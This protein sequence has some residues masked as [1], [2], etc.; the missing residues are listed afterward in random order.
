MFPDYSYFVT[1]FLL[2]MS[3]IFC[4]P[5]SI[6]MAF[7]EFGDWKIALVYIPIFTL[8]GWIIDLI[9]GNT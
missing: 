4:V 1:I 3:I 8:G 9:L 5:T 7:F 2:W 6:I